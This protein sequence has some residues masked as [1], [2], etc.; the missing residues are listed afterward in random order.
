MSNRESMPV[1]RHCPR[2]PV[3][4][5]HGGGPVDCAGCITW[6]ALGSSAAV[7]S[8][9]ASS[10]P[11]SPPEQHKT[12]LEDYLDHLAFKFKRRQVVKAR[13]TVVVFGP[14]MGVWGKAKYG[15]KPLRV[16]AIGFWQDRYVREGCVCTGRGGA[17]WGKEKYGI[18]PLRVDAIGFWQDRYERDGCVGREPLTMS[19]DC[20][21]IPS[22]RPSRP[23]RQVEGLQ[24][25]AT[26]AFL[27]LTLSLYYCL[28]TPSHH[29]WQ[30]E[31]AR[32]AH[33]RGTAHRL[34]KAHPLGTGHIQASVTGLLSEGGLGPEGQNVLVA[35]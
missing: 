32:P 15:I 35:W 26:P 20:V 14:G 5:V 10:A 27:L 30:A 4:S 7:K 28:R 29:H 22:D 25:G 6:L 21:R 34:H 2:Y 9:A 13:R 3:P 31:G 17:A 33:Q 1:S 8:L 16:D 12:S 11:P 18:K 24:R 19:S 23:S